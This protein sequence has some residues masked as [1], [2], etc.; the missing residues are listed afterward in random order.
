[1]QAA[2]GG[3]RLAGARRTARGVARALGGC[4]LW[5]PAPPAPLSYPLNSLP[6][7]S[8][9]PQGTVSVLP[10]DLADRASVATF[11]KHV[12]ADEPRVDALLNNAGEKLGGWV[13]G[14][15]AMR[16][17]GRRG[18]PHPAPHAPTHAKLTLT[19]LKPRSRP[20]RHH[21]LSLD[22]HQ[23]WFRVAGG[24]GMGVQGRW[25][26]GGTAPCGPACPTGEPRA[27]PHA[28][29]ALK[30]SAAPPSQ[31]GTN[32]HGHFLLTRSLLPKLE[33]CPAPPARVVCVASMAHEFGGPPA[34]DLSDL[35]W[36]ARP[37]DRCQEIEGLGWGGRGCAPQ[38]LAAACAAAGARCPEPLAPPHPFPAIRQP[39]KVQCVRRVQAGQHPARPSP[40]GPLRPRKG[41]S[42]RGRGGGVGGQGEAQCGLLHLFA[43]F[44]PRQP[45]RSLPPPRSWPSLCTRASFRLGCSSTWARP[46]GRGRAR[47]SARL[48]ALRAPWAPPC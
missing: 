36:R 24:R 39:P 31:M 29:T 47:P 5:R 28:G 7:T 9:T 2:Q 13:K 44:A 6:C 4:S 37:Y 1:M 23:R 11:A 14:V 20:C 22:R 32:H 48:P 42:E 8:P 35:H 27:T 19:A 33:A 40:G 16:A 15:G 18:A 10:L 26:G 41:M 38:W 46:R 43:P 34:M 17:W 21:G 30:T 25:R 12:A 45:I 3:R